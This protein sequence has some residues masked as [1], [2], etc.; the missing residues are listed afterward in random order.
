[1]LDLIGGISRSINS[2]S[3]QLLAF[4]KP[5]QQDGIQGSA[6]GLVEHYTSSF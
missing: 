6:G 5:F 1:M 3:Q 4:C 2:V